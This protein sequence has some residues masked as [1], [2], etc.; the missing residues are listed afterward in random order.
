LSTPVEDQHCA[1][2]L[3]LAMVPQLRPQGHWAPLLQARRQKPP[4]QENPSSHRIAPVVP[5][6]SEQ[7]APS[8]ARRA[9]VWSPAGLAG[10]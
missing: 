7:D 3:W 1:Q 9:Q 5:P 6:G 10:L 4:T 8:V 2:T